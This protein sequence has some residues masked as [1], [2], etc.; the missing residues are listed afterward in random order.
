MCGGSLRS[1]IF[2]MVYIFLPNT[3]LNRPFYHKARRR[4][5]AHKRV[6]V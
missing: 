1:T 5:L 3:I 6:K 4:V 2:F